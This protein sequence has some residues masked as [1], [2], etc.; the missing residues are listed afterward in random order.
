MI[1]EK[2]HKILIDAAAAG[3]VVDREVAGH[4]DGC[5][6]CRRTLDRERELFAAIDDRLR[7]RVNKQP[8]ASFLARMDSRIA[9]HTPRK[10]RWSPKW[11]AA[12]A[13]L[14]LIA[15]AH[16][17]AG[18]RKHTVEGNLRGSAGPA[19]ERPRIAKS[20]AGAREGLRRRVR[21]AS[22]SMVEP[23]GNRE[24]EVL[25]PAD[26]AE[27]FAQFVARVAG[28]DQRAEAV[29]WPMRDQAIENKEFLEMQL[30]DLADLQVEPAV[31]EWK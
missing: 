25:V 6:R 18:W 16:P 5:R 15:M 23:A 27:A 8:S 11:A 14:V 28:R 10:A 30:V 22:Q 17:W 12:A 2:Y 1:C 31:W 3:E 19:L 13:A 29:V 26:E 24:P 9:E 7:A 4:V 20:V 21:L